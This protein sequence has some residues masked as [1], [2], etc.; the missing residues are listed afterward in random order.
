MPKEVRRTPLVQPAAGRPKIKTPR[1]QKCAPPKKPTPMWQRATKSKPET[2][3][4]ELK[5]SLLAAAKSRA[6]AK[7]VTFKLTAA[8][9]QVPEKCP[10]L[11]IR[12]KVNAGVVSPGSP[13][14]DRLDPARGYVPGNVEVISHRAN[15]I[16]GDASLAELKKLVEWMEARGAL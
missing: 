3:L 4:E 9:I 15:R 16:K 11:G 8:D 12:L 6:A 5:L 14:L 1:T 10:I 7:K 13:S 2:A